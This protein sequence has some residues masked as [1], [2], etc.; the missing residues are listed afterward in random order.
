MDDSEFIY[1]T[2]KDGCINSGGFCIKS[3]MLKNKISPIITL[4]NKYNEQFNEQNINKVSDIFDDLVLP[5]WAYLQ[6]RAIINNTDYNENLNNENIKY[7]KNYNND[8][9]EIIDDYLYNQ[10]LELVKEKEDTIKKEKKNESRKKKIFK[11][12]KLTLKN[13]NNNL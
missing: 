6:P 8:D 3:I 2:D 9:D 10:L 13:K 7:K 12:T 5:N 11:R 4:N 1:Y